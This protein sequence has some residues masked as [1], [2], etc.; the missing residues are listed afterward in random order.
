MI[1]GQLKVSVCLV[2]AKDL[3]P[4]INIINEIVNNKDNSDDDDD[5]NDGDNNSSYCLS[6]LLAPVLSALHLLS[7]FILITIM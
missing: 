7:H 1:L 3:R 5:N 6:L 2:K 4:M